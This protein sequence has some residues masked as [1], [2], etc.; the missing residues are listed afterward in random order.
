M[1]DDLRPKDHSAVGGAIGYQF[2]FYRALLELLD[3]HLARDHATLFLESADDY[4]VVS[5]RGRE[6]V[7]VKHHL[8][9][10]TNTL[11][12]LSPD[13]WKTIAVWIDTLAQ[14]EPEDSVTLTLL[15]TA[16]AP[17]SSAAGLLCPESDG[18][19]EAA[20][21]ALLK[22]VSTESKNQ[23]TSSAR[24]RFSALS[25]PDQQRLVS[26]I[27]VLDGVPSARD[28]GF[29]LRERLKLFIH[30]PY[31]DDF[32]NAVIGWWQSQCISML[33][34]RHGIETEDL[35]AKLQSL[36]DDYRPTSLPYAWDITPSDEERLTYETRLF[37]GQLRWVA[38]SSAMLRRAID[39][40]HRSYHNKSRWLRIGIIGRD[41]LDDYERRLV[42]AWG[43]AR[44]WM[45]Y[46]LA[47]INDADRRA[48]AGLE[49]WTK[50]SNSPDVVLRGEFHEQNLVQGSY[51]ELADGGPDRRPQLG[52]HPEFEER[53]RDLLEPAT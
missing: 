22:T 31:V 30:P 4:E 50:V 19:N 33:R 8:K 18:R 3:R 26:S 51:H 35:A 20:A 53:L 49:L 11:T 23:A 36:R 27:V 28:Y 32:T 40:Y 21:L 9:D 42:D 5:V 7:Q 29:E 41:E 24:A 2:Q 12:D 1:T 14:V 46:E 10:S 17:P 16:V 39:D 44:E 15:S 38:A 48:K 52:W 43:R 45:M 47:D 13:V 37:I 6:T 34:D 25:T